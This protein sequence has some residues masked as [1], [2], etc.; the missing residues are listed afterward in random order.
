MVENIKWMISGVFVGMGVAAVIVAT[1]KKLQN[2]IAD[3]VEK[4]KEKFDEIKSTVKKETEKNKKE[5][6]IEE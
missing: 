1:N 5:S 3:C 6:K 4:S 2:K